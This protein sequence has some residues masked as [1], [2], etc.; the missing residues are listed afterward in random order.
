L[1]S[2]DKVHQGA[3]VQLPRFD[4]RSDSGFRDAIVVFTGLAEPFADLGDDALYFFA[5]FRGQDG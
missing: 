4:K 2:F 5:S 3:F 1:S